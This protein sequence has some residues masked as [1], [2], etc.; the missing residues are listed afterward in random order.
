[1]G[2]QV[3]S[4]AEHGLSVVEVLLAIA[5]I[6]ILAGASVVSSA[7]SASAARARAAAEHV[8]T[9]LQGAFDLA[10]SENTQARVRFTRGAWP[11]VAEVLRGGSWVN[12]TSELAAI[13]GAAAPTGPVT[14][15]STT[16]P[17]DTYTVQRDASSPIMVA[18]EGEV[19]VASSHGMTSRVVTTRLGRACVEVCQ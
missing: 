16:Y 8:V 10:A 18:T 1:M 14:V 6:A 3:T 5:L 11:P 4:N 13:R 12:V 17:G 15:S 7:R 19:V 2:S 9:L